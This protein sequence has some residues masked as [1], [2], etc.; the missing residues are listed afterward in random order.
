MLVKGQIPENEPIVSIGLV[1]P[2]DEQKSIEIEFGETKEKIQIRANE[3]NL[4][5][6]NL[7][8]KT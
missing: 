1:L 4:F 8:C 6:N 2:V 5:L 7:K 3:K